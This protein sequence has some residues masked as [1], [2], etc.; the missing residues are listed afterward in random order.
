MT[1][2]RPHAARVAGLRAHLHAQRAEGD[3]LREAIRA[4]KLSR[5]LALE[6][7]RAGDGAPALS[8]VPWLAA[9]AAAT[10]SLFA[11]FCAYAAT[12]GA[13]PVFTTFGLLSFVIASIAV[14]VARRP[15]AGGRARRSLRG[16]ATLL[17]V[18]SAVVLLLAAHR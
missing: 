11:V 13:P 17:S 16:L 6:L 7:L 8:L 12:V 2:R 4:A 18:L 9:I 1:A 3:R 5:D 10:V 15:G 14:L